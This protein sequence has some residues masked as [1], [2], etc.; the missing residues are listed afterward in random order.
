MASHAASTEAGCASKQCS[1]VLS[2]EGVVGAV[3]GIL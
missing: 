1:L 2:K 3:V